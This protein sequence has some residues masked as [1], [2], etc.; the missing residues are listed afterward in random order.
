MSKLASFLQD[1]TGASAAQYSLILALGG[2]AVAAAMM[3]LGDAIGESARGAAACLKRAAT[4]AGQVEIE[5]QA[6]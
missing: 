5:T 2:A 6:G 3:L 1:D 4:C